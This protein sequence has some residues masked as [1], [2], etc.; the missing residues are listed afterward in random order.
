MP[1]IKKRADYVT[2]AS[3]GDGVVEA[4]EK[5]VLGGAVA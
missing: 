2:E 3:Y 5:F 1:E 4:L